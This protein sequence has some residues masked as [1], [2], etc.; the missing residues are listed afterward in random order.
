MSDHSDSDCS[1]KGSDSSSAV[2]D[3]DKKHSS[4]ESASSD[5]VLVEL[6]ANPD[7]VLF[8]TEFSFIYR[9][10]KLNPESNSFYL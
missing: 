1:P 6:P 5:G 8:L 9:F 10:C 2:G 3:D 4:D 7:Q